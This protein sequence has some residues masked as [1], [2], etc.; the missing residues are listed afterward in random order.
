MKPRRFS[1]QHFNREIPNK[2]DIYKVKTG[3]EMKTT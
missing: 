1:F 3:W 2:Q